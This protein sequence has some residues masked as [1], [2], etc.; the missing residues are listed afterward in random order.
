MRNSFLAGFQQLELA[1]AVAVAGPYERAGPLPAWRTKEPPRS[2]R[3][4][5]KSPSCSL[6]T[7]RRRKGGSAQRQR[8]ED[9]GIVLG[10]MD[11]RTNEAGPRALNIRRRRCIGGLPGCLSL[12]TERVACA[13]GQRNVQ[14]RR[15]GI[16]IGILYSVWCGGHFF[17]VFF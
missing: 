11:G 9:F 13:T 2:G 14:A 4:P 12:S 8:D 3:I 5:V 16:G 1:V 7:R 10:W 17:F 6:I 15:I